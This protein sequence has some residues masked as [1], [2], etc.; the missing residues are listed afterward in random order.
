MASY[1]LAAG[2][3]ILACLLAF[4]LLLSAAG[5]LKPGV[6]A[7]ITTTEG[8]FTVKLYDKQA[9]KTVENFTALAEG[10]REWTDPRTGEKVKKPYYNGLIFHRV[11]QGA[12]IQGG[13]PTA[14]GSGGPGY[15]FDDEFDPALTH[16][17]AGI[18]S[19][20][21]SGRNTNGGQ[22]FITLS[23]LPSLDGKHTIFGEVVEGMNV[24]NKI[25]SVKV[26]PAQNNRP[27]KDVVI[28]TVTIERVA[29][30]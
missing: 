28:Q 17:K 27:V 15:T 14:T 8:S 30:R 13:D 22:F 16:S 25:G 6:Y 2:R 19:M 1:R 12:I 23:P 21:N 7:H 24:V 29:A 4:P 20:A 18:V 26:D 9:P 11:I 10:S 3:A 5:K